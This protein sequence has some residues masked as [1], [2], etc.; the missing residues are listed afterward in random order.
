MPYNSAILLRRKVAMFSN[1]TLKESRQARKTTVR[2]MDSKQ[3]T[4]SASFQTREAI[5]WRD[6]MDCSVATTGL[7]DHGQV[8]G[9]QAAHG[10]RS[11]AS[12]VSVKFPN[13]QVAYQHIGIRSTT[14][15]RQI[16]ILKQISAF[17]SCPTS[18][19][20][21]LWRDQG[22]IDANKLYRTTIDA[23]I[24]NDRYIFATFAAPG[25]RRINLR[26]MLLTISYSTRGSMAAKRPGHI[27]KG[28]YVFGS[29]ADRLVAIYGKA[30]F[31]LIQKC[32]DDFPAIGLPYHAPDFGVLSTL[33]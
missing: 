16:L 33:L 29:V 14:K 15:F 30:G 23:G 21:T 7:Q 10:K 20:D 9:G 13:A 26:R 24:G 11:S 25:L 32:V 6:N 4:V 18:A 17:A 28:N 8:Y 12:R 2:S 22:M 3:R 1:W 5:G 31:E 27:L 19:A